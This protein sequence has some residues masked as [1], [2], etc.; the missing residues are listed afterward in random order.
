[1]I[2]SAVFWI[3]GFL[4]SLIGLDTFHFASQKLHEPKK[5]KPKD[6]PA[7]PQDH[8]NTGTS[9]SGQSEHIE[10]QGSDTK[11]DTSWQK[12]W[13]TEKENFIFF[14]KRKF[15]FLAGFFFVISGFMS[16]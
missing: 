2:T 9:T 6:K 10:M 1:M 4:L 14:R 12:R 11:D 13:K 7:K 15:S 16:G 3:C 5:H 8:E